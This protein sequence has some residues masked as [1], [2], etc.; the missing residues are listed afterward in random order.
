ME[1]PSNGPAAKLTTL[2]TSG[3]GSNLSQLLGLLKSVPGN[4]KVSSWE[5][6][7]QLP[8]TEKSAPGNREVSS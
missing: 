1:D 2:P 3:A 7:S 6:G 8:G 4:Q 5:P